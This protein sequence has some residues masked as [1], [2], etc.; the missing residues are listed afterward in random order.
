ML[1]PT[2]GAREWSALN[3]PDSFGRKTALTDA[4]RGFRLRKG[5]SQREAALGIGVSQ[6]ALAK[7]ES[8]DSEP[9]DTNLLELARGLNLTNEELKILVET[10]TVQG[11]SVWRMIMSSPE[12]VDPDQF[13]PR[14]ELIRED[15]QSLMLLVAVHAAKR[16]FML[17][18]QWL[19]SFL[20]FAD[21]YSGVLMNAQRN[22]ELR[23]FC[24]S[25]NG[26]LMTL[27]DQVAAQRMLVMGTL[28]EHRIRKRLKVSQANWLAESATHWKSGNTAWAFGTAGAIYFANKD[29]HACRHC[30]LQMIHEMESAE[31]SLG[32]SLAIVSGHLYD[33]GFVK[34]AV[35]VFERFW[36]KH[37][38]GA[39]EGNPYEL[40]ALKV[41]ATI[42]HGAGDR[43]QAGSMISIAEQKLLDCDKNGQPAA[44]QSIS[45]SIQQTKISLNL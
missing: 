18:G 3:L 7:W 26:F 30:M 17:N 4:I 23:E 13:F 39:V 2:S 8:G 5:L 1:P 42:Y 12:P 22:I 43:D 27:Q 16:R 44:Y 19:A 41:A 14:Y 32:G 6:V 45:D 29:V 20:A 38:K 33:C 37:W 25:Q 24:G 34:E 40:L 10:K 31:G 35:T 11:P 28:A 21:R 36:D 9:S 15:G